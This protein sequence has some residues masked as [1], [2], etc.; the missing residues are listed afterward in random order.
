MKYYLDINDDELA[1]QLQRIDDDKISQTLRELVE[2]ESSDERDG[3]NL[4]DKEQRRE[5][6]RFLRGERRTD[7]RLGR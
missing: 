3:E 1:E 2:S 5:L 4:S 7:P 6:Q